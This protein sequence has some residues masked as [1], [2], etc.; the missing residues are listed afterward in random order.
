MRYCPN[1]NNKLKVFNNQSIFTTKSYD[2]KCDKCN[3]QF[4]HSQLTDRYNTIC[5]VIFFSV[6]LIFIDDIQYYINILVHNIFTANVII[7]ALTLIVFTIINNYNFPWT[8]YEV[9]C[10]KELKKASTS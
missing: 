7:M 8:K 10:K 4:S 2:L 5:T 1:C 9:T 6:I 3:T